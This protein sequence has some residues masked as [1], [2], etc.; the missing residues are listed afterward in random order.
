VEFREARSGLKTTDFNKAEVVRVGWGAGVKTEMK[1]IV[2]IVLLLVLVTSTLAGCLESS[3]PE[4]TPTPTP[5]PVPTATPTISPDGDD[6]YMRDIKTRL[7][8]F[9]FDIVSM[10]VADGR[11]KGGDKALILTYITGDDISTEIGGITGA[12]AIAIQDGWDI[13]SMV[14]VMGDKSGNAVGTWYCEV[15]WINAY[16]D[17]EIRAVE[18]LDNVINTLTIF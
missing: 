13:D 8:R 12:F 16:H 15:D 5:T 11:A 4:A 2:T 7:V 3:T 1:K 17:D 18:M 9:G 6:Y 14:V 10:D